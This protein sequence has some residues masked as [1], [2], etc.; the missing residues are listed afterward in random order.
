MRLPCDHAWIRAFPDGSRVSP[1]RVRAGF[2]LSRRFDCFRIPVERVPDLSRCALDRVSGAQGAGPALAAVGLLP[3]SV[4][5]V[6]DLL[7]RVRERAGGS[8]V[9]D[10]RARDP[11]GGRSRG[12][13]AGCLSV[14][15]GRRRG[16]EWSGAARPRPSRRTR[17][18]ARKRG[19]ARPLPDACGGE[20]VTGL[21]GWA[22]SPGL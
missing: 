6:G 8:S 18:Q 10:R 19:V 1:H 16:L 22:S 12:S 4:G 14:W 9:P 5:C 21:R 17:A 11:L 7:R 20:C 15:A 13:L 3:G 2:V